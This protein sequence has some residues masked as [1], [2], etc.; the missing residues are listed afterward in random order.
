[1]CMCYFYVQ[2]IQERSMS[3]FINYHIPRK[4][5]YIGY[6]AHKKEYRYRDTDA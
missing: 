2:K 3:C 4:D 5:K 1:M 6:L